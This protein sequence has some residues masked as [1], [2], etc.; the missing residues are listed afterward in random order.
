[1]VRSLWTAA[2][3]MRAEQVSMD[4]LSNNIANV[5]TTGYKAQDTQFKSLLYQTLQEKTTTA[6][7]DPKPTEAQVGLGTRVASLKS[8]FAQ[9]AMLA[10]NNKMALCISNTA[11]ASFFSVTGQD[12]Q[13]YYTRDGNLGW[14][15]DNTGQRILTNSSGNPVLDTQGQRIRLPE[16]AGADA[17]TVGADGAVGYKRPDGGYVATGQTIGL[18]QFA[19][20]TGLAKVSNNLYEATNASGAAINEATTNLQITRSTIAQGYL[21]GSNVNIADEMVTMIITQ[22]A[23]ELNS[24]AITTSD[25]MLDTANN[26]KR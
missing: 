18:F 26:L 10:S 16:G 23:Y 20:P 5:N 22:R 15:L 7:G 11:T 17:V 19:N 12:G 24:K 13:V 14:T 6:N 25:S 9:G 4:T 21:E 3:G 8:N 1:M 2:S